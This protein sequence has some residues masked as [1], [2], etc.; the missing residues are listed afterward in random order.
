MVGPRFIRLRFSRPL[1]ARPGGRRRIVGPNSIGFVGAVAALTMAAPEPANAGCDDRAPASNATAT[2]DDSAPNPDT[3]GVR[4]RAGSSDVTVIVEQGAALAT[5]GP[6]VLTRDRSRVGNDGTIEADASDNAAVRA[7]GGGNAIVNNGSI[8]TT[9][10]TARGILANGAGNR[11]TNGGVLTTAGP[12]SHAIQAAGSNNVIVNSGVTTVS[13]DRARGIIAGPGASVSNS[14]TVTADGAT[15]SSAISFNSSGGGTLVN[16]ESGEIRAPQGIGVIGLDGAERIENSGTIAGGTAAMRLRDGDDTVVITGTSVFVGTVDAEEGTDRL[17]LDGPASGTISLSDIGDSAQYRN[18]EAFEKTGAGT[19]TVTGSGGQTWSVTDGTF[20]VNGSLSGGTTITGGA[21]LGGTGSLGPVAVNGGTFAPGNGIGTQTVNGDLSFTAG[22][23]LEVETAPTGEGD[24]IVVNGGVS[25]GGA[26][27]AVLAEAGDYAAEAQYVII[28]NDGTD[29]VTGEFSTVTSNLAF[30]DPTVDTAADDGNDV[31]LLLTRNDVTFGA[32][33]GTDNQDSV[34]GA[35]DSPGVGAT[36]DFQ[37]IVGAITGL[38]AAQ[39]Q[40]AFDSLAGDLHPTLHVLIVRNQDLFVRAIS[41]HLRPADS[42]NGEQAA[43]GA[44]AAD[45]FRLTQDASSGAEA[46]DATWGS[47]RLWLEALSTV[48]GNLEGDTNAA[49]ADYTIAGLAS[50]VD[51]GLAEAWRIGLAVSFSRLDANFDR[52][53]GD[54]DVDS[55]A[56]A[57]YGD[58]TAGSISFDAVASYARNDVDTSRDIVVGAIRRQ[59]RADYNTDLITAQIGTQVALPA[60]YRPFGLA[61]EPFAAVRADRIMQEDFEETGADS[62]DLNVDSE[63]TVSL[64]SFAGV[65]VSKPIAT[66]GGIALTPNAH[67]SWE[68]EYLDKSGDLSARFSGG[69]APLSIKGVETARDRANIGASLT[70]NTSPNSAFYA[71]YNARISKDETAHSL[72]GGFRL[73]W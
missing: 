46:S 5:D 66:M 65:S 60:A 50:G 28:A 21:R 10:T 39:A 25:L 59:A 1:P 6:A 51:V 53:S 47:W 17:V 63:T 32:L 44:S 31:V 38:S 19:W 71:T 54:G 73:V 49:G 72:F 56:A 13:G 43:N 16:D 62:V 9:G 33:G 45:G 15:G 7:F 70:V 24:Q 35:T 67:A 64:R 40:S 8:T 29:T 55:Y 41:R 61:I 30:L 42:V 58:Y 37:A 69:G 2:C 48:N 57:V 22:S 18:F 34:G 14:G 36:A 11:I 52:F 27:L 20:L 4:A 68:H 3:T 12:N 26:S 23:V